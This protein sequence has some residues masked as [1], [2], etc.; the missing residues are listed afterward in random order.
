MYKNVF[1]IV[2][3]RENNVGNKIIKGIS[4]G[5]HFNS[6]FCAQGIGMRHTFIH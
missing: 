5:F 3:G 2:S 1:I 4:S 6:F